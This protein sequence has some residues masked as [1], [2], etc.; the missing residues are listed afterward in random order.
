[1]V[2][3]QNGLSALRDDAKEQTTLEAVLDLIM[4]SWVENPTIPRLS[5]SLAIN[6]PLA[7]GKWNDKG[8]EVDR[9]NSLRV[10]LSVDSTR[11]LVPRSL[12]QSLQPP[13][14]L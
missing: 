8:A 10:I 9:K 12:R 3:Q 5:T 4:K 7:S 6:P 14:E 2:I 11:S 1:M 13:E